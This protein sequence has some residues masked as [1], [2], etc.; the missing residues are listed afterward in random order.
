MLVF[1]QEAKAECLNSGEKDGFKTFQ[2]L[3]T[4]L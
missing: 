1:V 4:K 3:M 2:I